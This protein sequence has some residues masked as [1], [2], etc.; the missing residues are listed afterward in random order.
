MA[1]SNSGNYHALDWVQDEIQKSLSVALKNL[2]EALH[3]SDNKTLLNTCI[4]QLHQVVGTLDMLDL[5][6]ATQLAEE[7]LTST[8]ALRDKPSGHGQSND[9]QDSVLK[10]LLLLPNYLQ[11]LSPNLQDHPLRL[12]KTIN[13]LRSNRSEEEIDPLSLFKPN[14]SAPLPLNI[15]PDPDR[16]TPNTK[17]SPAKIY[18]L[19]QASLLH[20]LKNN[21]EASLRKMNNIVHFLR[22]KC[23]QEKTTLFWWSAE[24]VIEG[25]LDKG[26]VV[27]ADIRLNLG[28]LNQSVKYFTEQD[29][30][31]LLA[32]FPKSLLQNLLFIVATSSSTGKNTE[33]LK[34]VFRL[35][36]FNKHQ[37][38][39]IYTFG[40]EA[41]TEAYKALLEQTQKIKNK[42]EQSE[43][44]S[45][46]ENNYISEQLSSLALTL[47]LLSESSA[48]N[49]IKEQAVVFKELTSKQ[50]LPN[51][52]Q[53]MELADT[54]L[55]VEE[56]LLQD[57]HTEAHNYRES[58]HKQLKNTVVKECLTEL[59]TVKEA[60]ILLSD[61]NSD[62]K[63]SI[64]P[65]PKQLRNI[66]GS[67]AILELD[68]VAELLNNT[69]VQITQ[70]ENSGQA[71]SDVELGLFAEVIISVD[72]YLEGLN[73]HG[74]QQ[75]NVLEEA[76]E[77]IANFDL[78]VLS[79]T[80][81]LH[82]LPPKIDFPEPIDIF[83]EQAEIAL[84]T[85]AND[86]AIPE[87]TTTSVE[88]YI[89]QLADDTAI[90]EGTETS[91]QPLDTDNTAIPESTETSVERYIQQLNTDDTAITESTETSVERYIQQLATNDD[92]I[93]AKNGVSVDEHINN[94]IIS[95]NTFNFAKDI[96]HE[97]AEIF[98][99][100][101]HEILAQLYELIPDWHNHH[102]M[103]TLVIIRRHFHSLKG[104]GRMAKAMVIGE[105][106]WSIEELLNKVLDGSQSVSSTLEKLLADTTHFIPELL[107][108]FGQGFTGSTEYTDELTTIA[109]ECLNEQPEQ[110]DVKE[111]EQDTSIDPKLRVIFYQEANQHI[112][113]FKQALANETVPFKLNKDFL[114]AAHSLKGC[115]NLAD[116]QSVATVAVQLDQSLRRLYEQGT[117]ID[118]Q[119]QSV[120]SQTIESIAQIVKEEHNKFA[121]DVNIQPLI[122]SLIQITPD[123]NTI[124]SQDKL[125]D[126]EFLVTFLE[127]TDDLLDTYGEQLNQLKQSVNNPEYQALTQQTLTTLIANAEHLNLTN[128]A[129]TYELLRHLVSKVSLENT[130]TLAL[131]EQGFELLNAQ[132]EALIQNKPTEGISGFNQQVT[133]HINQLNL[134]TSVAEITQAPTPEPD[135]PTILSAEEEELLVGFIEECAELL[136]SSGQAISQWNENNDDQEA[137]SQ[138]QR[139]LHTIKGGALMTGVNS[140]ADLSH[141]MESVLQATTS[142]EQPLDTS[143]FTL[144]Q[145]SH[146]HLLD[147]H[148]TLTDRVQPNLNNDLLFDIE[149]YLHLDGDHVMTPQKNTN[150]LPVTT[151]Q[152]QPSLKLTEQ[153]RIPAVFL[154]FMTNFAGEANISR[155]R[156]SLQNTAI[157]QQ[158][159]EME[160]TVTRLQAQFRNLEIETETQILFRYED[161]LLDQKL[162]VFDPLEL[163]RFSMIQQLSRGLTESV[164]DLNDITESLNTLI[165]DSDTILLQQSLLSKEL[166]QGLMKTR[167][168]PFREIESR[169]ERIVRQA[170]NELEQNTALTI[171]GLDYELD[172]SILNRLSAPLEHILR[173][174]IF[175]GIE[176]EESRLTLGKPVQGQIVLTIAREGS[177]ILVT[178]T[179]DG[180]G[181]NFDA[182]E[183][184]ALELGLISLNDKPSNEQLIQFILGSGF[185]TADQVSQLAGRG[186]GLDVVN[187]EI[188][189]LKG[190]LTIQSVSNQGVSFTI[191]LPLS[192]TVMQSLLVN[193]YDQQYALPLSA[194]HTAE[195][196]SVRDVNTL[197]S[198]SE[199]PYYRYGGLSYRFTPLATILGQPFS[200]P[201]DLEEQLPLLLFRTGDTL[202]AL[203]VESIVSSREIVL[204]SVGEQLNTIPALSGATILGDGNVAFILDIPALVESDKA[205]TESEQLKPIQ[206]RHTPIALIVD[207]SI[208][209]RKASGN[210]L[211]RHGFDIITAR[212]GVDAVNQ[213]NL[214][215]PDIILLDIEMPR[216][217][218]FEFATLVRNNAQYHDLPIIMI[219]S[220]TGDK[221]RERAQELGVNAYMGKPYQEEQ[222]VNTMQ[223]LLGE[224]YPHLEY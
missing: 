3:Q 62:S 90:S 53:C 27:S 146:D 12:I 19:F 111:D 87:S 30:Y 69:A 136:E 110:G 50:I 22:L 82:Q 168:T 109:Q 51:N 26:L 92:V 176:D 72:L 28:K 208:T 221:H 4:T 116:V 91:P 181:L 198:Q 187:R 40:D 14:L 135:S 108:L 145:R 38:Q 61:Y 193:S 49:S 155:D 192:L 37:Q 219:T 120:L 59:E 122:D 202:V 133:E 88:R 17:L 15:V 100:E 34:K 158:L 129:G 1:Q 36:F 47:D 81:E 31:D 161:E 134:I 103:D 201:E 70:I 106:A 189:A 166:Q 160:T 200:L 114:R 149:Q 131:L 104:S 16:A 113:S 184:K 141:H 45:L 169:L 57:Q 58:E 96:D 112:G 175:H 156:V 68:A 52:E 18:H 203:L 97:I 126:P 117:T 74:Q 35:T 199:E 123:E 209:M 179:D 213:L 94:P 83:D 84:E 157:R 77:L 25:L 78:F 42:L 222:L 7:I 99:S 138:L 93:T 195:R 214:Q 144:L 164:S 29:E 86:T 165:G 32:D 65:L 143:F 95:E 8:I 130:E 23:I 223:K 56:Y 140:I 188:R 9:L 215:I 210:L 154:D 191:R 121:D 125:I 182:I 5:P 194:I 66:A 147:L 137:L 44:A 132:I 148:T 197:Y 85:D 101:A 178:I 220:R 152:S 204:K 162:E 163:D 170:N 54:L 217:D 41:L 207:D 79:R 119:L 6:G 196:I 63:T 107:T 211:K 150:A 153:V 10:G 80:E 142:G 151:T 71:F 67:L 46:T 185:S 118:E 89:Q 159:T 64:D 190:R 224:N 98:I 115:A 2:G 39:Q 186:V 76:N 172:R 212:D 124:P 43:G 13:E 180:R 55:K 73:Q 183:Q 20:W 218:G 11:L 75:D 216:M 139:D 177:E 24:G 174:S 173:N 21:D 167:L 127:E 48:H 102:N 205:L 60:L 171:R 33:S 206:A 128:I 105:L